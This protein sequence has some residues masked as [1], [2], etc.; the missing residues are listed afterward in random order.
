MK[1]KTF[2]LSDFY[3]LEAD[4]K[5]LNFRCEKTNLIVWPILREEFFNLVISKLY[6]E[7][8]FINYNVKNNLLTKFVPLYRSIKF[9]LFLK[10]LF[11]NFKQ[12]DILFFKT[13]YSEITIKNFIFDRNIDYF[14]SLSKKNYVTFSRSSKFSFFKKYFDNQTYFLSFN[15]NNIHLFSR[16]NKKNY[17]VSSDITLYLSKKIKD[18]F[19]IKLNNTEIQR[20]IKYNMFR[21]NAIDKKLN[22][23]KKLIKKIKPKLAII[24]CA[25]Y[26]QNAILNYALQDSGVRIAEPQHGNISEAHLNYN[27]SSQIKNSKEYRLFLPNDFLSY[28]KYWSKS[29]NAPLTKYDVG[30]PHQS[31]NII[32]KSKKFKRKKILLVSDGI[33]INLFPN[34]A[35][36]IFIQL[37][38]EYEI[39][40]RPH[41]IENVQNYKNNK[42]SNYFKIDMEEN[43]Y[44]SLIDKEVVIAEM[45]TVL[46]DALNIV[47][48]IFILRTKK[49]IFNVPNH[50]FEEVKNTEEL[51]NKIKNK[52]KFNT[53]VIL[54][55]YYNKN[56]K[57]NFKNYLKKII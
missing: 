26:S 23:Y 13:G 7:S 40:I 4:L 21:I 37:N 19:N 50:P 14:I 8:E 45:S 9:S 46:Y 34:L 22:F 15:E 33:N 5:I 6:Y 12:K 31:K 51:I 25:S 18:V 35:K 44:K 36:K 24:E 3:L 54:K 2:K 16:F 57:Q 48:K 38:K 42:F 49:S 32:Y 43:V 17:K 11:F 53:K 1:K 27:F 39:F 55:K 29:I 10:N 28:G 41:P 30:S 47:P 56:W 20:L 52:K